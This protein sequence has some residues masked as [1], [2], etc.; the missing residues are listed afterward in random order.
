MFS[1]IIVDFNSIKRTIKYIKSLQ[2]HCKEYKF[3]FIVV[4]NG[5]ENITK[6]EVAYLYKEKRFIEGYD[7]F[8]YKSY[9]LEF[10]I[11]FPKSNLGYA[12]GNN[13]GFKVERKLYN[14]DYLLVSNNDI[15]FSS[16]LDFN[17]IKEIFESNSKIGII[18]PEVVGINGKRQSPYMIEKPID[19]LILYYWKSMLNFKNINDMDFS[20]N[21]G[22]CDY[23]AGSFVFIR[24]EAFEAV[25]GYDS[26]TFLYGE[27]IILSTKMRI[28]GYETYFT[29]KFR[30]I[31]NHQFEAT[32]KVN[33]QSR[34]STISVLK[35]GF[36]S[37]KY[38]YRKYDK[39]SKLMICFANINFSAFQTLYYIAHKLK[40]KKVS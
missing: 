15:V 1:V 32:N 18:G 28:E 22:Y 29:N 39:V 19:R 16:L 36:D 24:S 11:V 12:K 5:D 25:G 38:Y 4:E 33:D 14:S 37:A 30:V 8:L 23:V 34:S 9:D 20:I 27:E 7:V 35:Y 40:G 26:E 6:K 21:E 31:H 17:K 3:S 13:L 2:S 10:N